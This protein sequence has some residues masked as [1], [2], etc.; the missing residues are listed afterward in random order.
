MYTAYVFRQKLAK[1][2]HRERN[3]QSS[4]LR[5]YVTKCNPHITYLSEKLLEAAVAVWF[6]VLFL[7]STLVQ[8]LQAKRAHEVLRVEF[9]EHGRYAA[10]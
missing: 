8:L 7:E 6:V 5:P 2:R 10:T 3:N 9:A 4:A 1:P